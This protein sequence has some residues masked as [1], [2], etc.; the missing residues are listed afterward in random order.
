MKL[1]EYRSSRQQSD[2]QSAMVFVHGLLGDR[3][4]WQEVIEQIA[5]LSSIRCFGFDLPGHGESKSEADAAVD[6]DW[7]GLRLREHCESLIA[8]G[9]EKLVLVGYSL[10]ARLL[11]YALARD[12]LHFPQLQSVVFEGGNFGLQDPD[13]IV[14][15]N[16]NDERWAQR[17]ETLEAEQVLDLWYQ[18]PVFSD[19]TSQQRRSLID[20]RKKNDLSSVA[21]LMRATSLAKQP[22]LLNEIQSHPMSIRLMVGENDKKF[23]TLYKDKGIPTIIV[24]N[25]GH[26]AHKD[27]PQYVAQA[28]VNTF[29]Q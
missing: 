24:P 8:T 11:M 21:T 17:F 18:Q 20:V 7:I 3:N 16:R 2:S 29:V 13:S 25:A 12:Y 27:N 5:S 15:R 6:F 26:N 1:T 10:G 23:R 19:M 28:L 22:N 14:E 4:D 9:V